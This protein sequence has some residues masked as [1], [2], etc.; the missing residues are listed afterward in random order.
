[1]NKITAANDEICVYLSLN[2]M[3]KIATTNHTI[4]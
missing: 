3:K 1:M 2:S 4:F